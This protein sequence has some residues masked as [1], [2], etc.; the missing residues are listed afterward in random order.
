M[1]F[2]KVEEC[3]KS[4]KEK[5]AAEVRLALLLLSTIQGLCDFTPEMAVICDLEL[6]VPAHKLP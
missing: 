1:S 5:W 3:V 4:L 6:S 2:E